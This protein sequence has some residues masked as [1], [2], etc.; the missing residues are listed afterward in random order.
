MLKGLSKLQKEY[1]FCCLGYG[2][3]CFI[4]SLVNAGYLSIK[5]FFAAT[6]VTFIGGAMSGAV[7]YWTVKKL[8]NKMLGI[9][10]ILCMV[11]SIILG[12]IS[13]VYLVVGLI[14]YFK[15]TDQDKLV[16]IVFIGHPLGT[17]LAGLLIFKNR[18]QEYIVSK[19]NT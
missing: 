10:L 12:C 17:A 13:L 7:M 14:E 19:E 5:V 3:F 11:F 9:F 16:S 1:S 15:T 2:L 6:F 8:Q 4:V 18:F